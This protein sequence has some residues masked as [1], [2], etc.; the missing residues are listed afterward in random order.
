MAWQEYLSLF[1]AIA[2]TRQ[3]VRVK[4]ES[5]QTSCGLAV[6]FYEFLSDRQHFRTYAKSKRGVKMKKD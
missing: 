2:G 5:V 4:V 1:P 6:P 3:I